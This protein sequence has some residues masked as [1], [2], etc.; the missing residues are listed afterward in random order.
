MN[1]AALLLGLAALVSTYLGG[2]FALHRQKNLHTIM[3]FSAGAVIGVAFFDLMPEALNLA[4]GTYSNATITSVVALGF[5]A[6]MLLNHWLIIH[7]HTLKEDE[8]CENP[9]HK[10]RQIGAGSLSV[11]SF[12]DGLAIG[13]AF[14]VSISV[15]LIVAVAVLIHDFSDGINT[16]T[17]TLKNQGTP[18]QALRW[19]LADAIAPLVGVVVTR[20]FTVPGPILGIILAVCCGFFLYIGA[21]DLLPESHHG[22]SKITTSLLTILGALIL[23]TAVHVAQI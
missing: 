4:G 15:G 11:H 8:H 10:R 7:P 2:I 13:L 19:L 6:F 17:L 22:H 12:L 23:Y 16:V 9:R 20:F 21:S 1:T 14:Q 18:G 5:L 3:A